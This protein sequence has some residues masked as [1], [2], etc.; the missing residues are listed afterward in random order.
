M[1]SDRACSWII[2]VAFILTCSLLA[3]FG[4]SKYQAPRQSE[5]VW[6]DEKEISWEIKD[7]GGFNLEWER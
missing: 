4:C 7:E 5:V 2:I 1:G 6:G 3:I